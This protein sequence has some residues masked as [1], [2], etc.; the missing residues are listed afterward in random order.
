MSIIVLVHGA[1]ENADTYRHIIPGLKQK[2]YKVINVNLPG[3][4]EDKTELKDISLG[5]Y[6]DKVLIEIGA[7]K[8]I[9]LVG[10]SLGGI[11][12]SAVAEKIAAQID[13]LIYIAA[14]IPQNGESLLTISKRDTQSIFAASLVFSEDHSTATIKPERLSDLFCADCNEEEAE[15]LHLSNQPE[16]MHPLGEVVTVTAQNFGR[17]PKYYVYAI[18]DWAIGIH[19]QKAMVADTPVVKSFSLNTGHNPHLSQ[20]LAIVKIIEEVVTTK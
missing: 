5:S 18:Q 4:G 9:I 17:I 1:F 6:L 15:A 13:K 14:F 12:I 2:G 7:E 10:H 8:N 3:H 20:P 16:P 19:L 11:I